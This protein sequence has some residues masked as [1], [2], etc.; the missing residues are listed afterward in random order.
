MYVQFAGAINRDVIKT[1]S[2][3]LIQGGWKVPGEERIGTAAGLH[4]IRCFYEADCTNAE[5][6]RDH[7]NAIF[8]D[9]FNSNKYDVAI[10]PRYNFSPKPRQGILEVWVELP[11][12]S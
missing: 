11:S 4:E 10:K 12:P 3:R 9:L 1:I 8:G 7:V 5:Q 2:A 6:L